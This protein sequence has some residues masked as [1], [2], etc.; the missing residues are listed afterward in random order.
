VLLDRCQR[1]L[2]SGVERAQS[3]GQQRSDDALRVQSRPTTRTED[4]R[5]LSELTRLTDE[6]ALLRK[7]LCAS[8]PLELQHSTAACSRPPPVT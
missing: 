4:A 7:A 5:V 6:V 8:L 3:L 2:K 1:L